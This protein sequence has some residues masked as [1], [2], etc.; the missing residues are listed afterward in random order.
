M[1]RDHV[2]MRNE[3]SLPKWQSLPKLP[4]LLQIRCH[5]IFDSD[6]NF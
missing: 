6:S 4:K 5:G 2:V 1:V 3:K